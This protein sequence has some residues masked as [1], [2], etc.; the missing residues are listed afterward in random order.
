[1]CRAAPGIK[2]DGVHFSFKVLMMVDKN[3]STSDDSIAQKSSEELFLKGSDQAETLRKKTDDDGLKL[4]DSQEELTLQNIQLGSEQREDIDRNSIDK[5]SSKTSNESFDIKSAPNIKEPSSQTEGDQSKL[6][7][8]NSFNFSSPNQQS[9]NNNNDQDTRR[10]LL[11]SE[12]HEQSQETVQV[13]DDNVDTRIIDPV[14]SNAGTNFPDDIADRRIEDLANRAPDAGEDTLFNVDEGAS[15]LSGQIVATDANTTD[16]L[17]Y[18]VVDGVDLPEGFTFSLDGSW[19]FDAQNEAYDHLNV[20]DSIVLT[21]PIIVSD[22]IGASDTTLI[23]ITI[24]GTNDAPVAGASVASNVDEGSTLLS[25]QLLSTDVD[26]GA[27]ASWS[28]SNTPSGF[29]L[30]N[31]GS[32]SFDPGDNAYEH[33]NVGDNQVISIPVTVTDDNGATDTSQIQITIS[34]TNDAPVAGTAITASVAEGLAVINGQLSSSDVDDGATAT[35]STSSTPA[36]FVLNADGSYSFDP[37]DSAYD[38]L[39]VGDSEVITVPVTVTDDNGATD[40]SQIQITVSGTN[41]AP[42]AGAHVNAAMDEGSAIFNGQLS[43]VDVD[44]GATTT[45]TITTGN[46]APDGFVLNADGSYGFD[47]ANSSYD[48]LNVGDSEV[49]TIPITVTD[50]NGAT[51]TSQIQITLSGTNDTP[52]AIVFSGGV[53]NENAPANTVVAQ[54]T[55]QDV[56]DNE[57]FTYSIVDD[58]SGFFQVSGDQIIVKSG[59]DIDFEDSQSH[60]V[61][62][63]VT[64]A[65]GLSYTQ[66]VSITVSDINEAPTDIVFDSVGDVQQTALR[67]NDNGASNEYASISNFDDFPTTAITLELQINS[68][69]ADTSSIAFASYATDGSNNEFLLFPNGGGNLEIY[70]NGSA[71]NTGISA[72][73]LIDGDTHQLSVTWD[74]Q[75]GALNVYVDGVEEYSGTHQQGSPITAGGTLIFGQEQDSVGGSFDSNQI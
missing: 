16:V 4:E 46:T 51:D 26:D 22:N 20:G 32:Y 56:D 72:S 73:D 17:S 31:D 45:Y 38:H 39:N 9:E 13:T 43:S 29:I 69:M 11:N 24:S 18:K 2:Q 59:A 49:L 12:Q 27:T 53:V 42:I 75:S 44:D 33:L 66:T 60:D 70:I 35:W 10:V 40:T 8:E 5:G 1:M 50:D 48:H 21:V 74:S 58:P 3:N 54:M 25:G 30:N 19:Q 7:E 34:G 52:T 55:T 23:K 57:T 36:G 28:T 15:L 67:V 41:D 6:L 47:P 68:D 65:N 64:D 63:Q 37:A 62:V 61:S 14:V 71:R